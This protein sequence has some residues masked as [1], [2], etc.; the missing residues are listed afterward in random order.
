MGGGSNCWTVTHLLNWKLRDLPKQ[1]FFNIRIEA[2]MYTQWKIPILCRKYILQWS[3]SHCYVSLPECQILHMLI[4]L[5]SDRYWMFFFW[6]L[7]GFKQGTLHPVLKMMNDATTKQF[8]HVSSNHFTQCL[9][10][11]PI[12]LVVEPTQVERYAHQFG[13]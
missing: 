10:N 7:V 3:I 9:H 12:Y 1:I 2:Y 8:Q 5:H 13:S 4:V 11:L 6:L